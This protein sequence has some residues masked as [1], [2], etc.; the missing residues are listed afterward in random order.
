MMFILCLKTD[1]DELKIL[2]K[3]AAVNNAAI[4]TL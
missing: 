2:R 1:Y 3:T 4:E